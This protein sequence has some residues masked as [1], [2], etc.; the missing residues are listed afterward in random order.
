MTTKTKSRSNQ[1][2]E[3]MECGARCC[4]YVALQIDDPESK[5]DFSDI[6]WY[7]CHKDVW[8]FIDHDDSW[9]VQFNTRCEFLKQDNTCGIYEKRPEI[10]DKHDPS[11]CEVIDD[12]ECQKFMLKT[13]EDLDMYLKLK[14]KKLSWKR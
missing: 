8:V 3:C 9:Y 7:L 14:G 1:V 4:Q 11:D 12:A 13:I 10:C 2:E 6:R 5:S